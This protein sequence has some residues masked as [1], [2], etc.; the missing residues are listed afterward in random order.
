MKKLILSLFVLLSVSILSIQAQND[1]IAR[2]IEL[3]PEIIEQLSSD[4]L[5][6][7][8]KEKQ[9]LKQEH[10]TAMAEKFGVNA[11][12]LVKDMMPSEFT[13]VLYKQFTWDFLILINKFT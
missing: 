12:D 11:Q 7:L 8:A 3:S 13:I 10:E 4:Q 2:A 5:L 1:S 6:E 9:R